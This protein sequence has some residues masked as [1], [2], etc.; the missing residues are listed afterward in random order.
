MRHLAR[1]LVAS[2]LIAALLT[3]ASRAQPFPESDS[4]KAEEA[5]KKTDEKATDEAYKATL[6]RTQDVKKTVDPW[7]NV[8]TSPAGSN[9]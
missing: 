3:P 5:R 8:R 1:S 6:K 9:K 2:L 4:Q 7:G